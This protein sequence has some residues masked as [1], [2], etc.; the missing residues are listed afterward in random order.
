MG[1]LGGWIK[2]FDTSILGFMN[3]FNG[4]QQDPHGYLVDGVICFDLINK[5]WDLVNALFMPLFKPS[6]VNLIYGGGLFK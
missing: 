5:D 4:L 3:Y 1:I 2:R 6:A